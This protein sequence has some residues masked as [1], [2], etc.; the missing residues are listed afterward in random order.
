MTLSIYLLG[1]AVL[2]GIDIYR[3]K[4]ITLFGALVI[5]LALSRVLGL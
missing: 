3:S 4:T 2:L 5:W 1:L